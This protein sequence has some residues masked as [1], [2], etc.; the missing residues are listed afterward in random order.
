M[1]ASTRLLVLLLFA[2]FVAASII[3][4]VS[5]TV[6]SSEN[7]GR[8]NVKFVHLVAFR[9][10][11]RNQ[12]QDVDGAWKS[13]SDKY[14]TCLTGK[15]DIL[16]YCRKV[17]PNENITNIVEYSHDVNVEKW[18]REDG[19]SCKFTHT[20]KPYRCIVGEFRSEALQVSHGCRFGH[21]NGRSYCKDYSYWQ[22]VAGD[23]CT[24]KSEPKPM[25]V[26]S[27]AML[28]P[29][30][31]DMFRGVEFVCCP[32]ETSDKQKKPN[33]VVEKTPEKNVDDDEEDDD[34]DDEDDYEEYDDEHDSSDQTIMQDAYFKEID[35]EN[36]HEKFRD[37]ERRLDKK[38]RA[39][40][41]K[42]INEWT[43]LMERY[44][45]MKVDDP[46][47]AEK[48]KTE[49]VARFRK[50]VASLE[51]ENREQRKQIED[52]HEERVQA[53][54]NE[55]KRQAT[56]DYRSALALQVG[57]PN[58]PNVLKTLKAY[59]RAE[60]K[61]RTHMLNRYRHL[62]RTDQDEAET[63]KD[64][65]LYR[66]RYIDL[67]INGTLAMLR[68]FP[69]LEKQVRPIAVEFWR[70]YRHENTPEISSEELLK[71][72]E[73][74]NNEKLINLYKQIY[75][76][77]RGND[78]V[79]KKVVEAS[80]ASP[81][82][83]TT[84]AKKSLAKTLLDTSDSDEDDEELKEAEKSV[85]KKDDSSKTAESKEDEKEDTES[86]EDDD[87]ED[88]EYADEDEDEKGDKKEEDDSEWHVVVEPIRSDT[89]RVHD[90]A[91]APPSYARHQPL[92]QNQV[93]GEE[94]STLMRSYTPYVIVMIITGTIFL[95]ILSV[96]F[97]RRRLQ[98]AGFIEV[99]V[100]TPEER[101]V[102]GMQVNGY[103]NPTYSFFDSKP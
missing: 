75:D 66:L 44:K 43:S 47:G 64:I 42:V 13:D 92:V 72:G 96:V 36:E 59:I 67:R 80:T 34:E 7:A 22:T 91:A 85:D 10:G 49:M 14:A 41:A 93:S 56:H 50:T 103:E 102:N 11:Y 90:L 19:K 77:L 57:K 25:K 37:A 68:D 26:Q 21:V 33:G 24:K 35:L 76:D 86:D 18:C 99:D 45:K 70:D 60:E 101:H 58:K 79:E 89:V 51:E 23:E 98:R 95:G 97:E 20:V 2:P 4:S 9:C 17:Y 84:A 87:D 94:S 55:K 5:A 52:V 31:L 82:T 73:N 38:H 78:E 39:K 40:V 71:L 16:K 48:F 100:C 54:L 32:G 8:D 53:S 28:E 15:L 29:C 81:V 83:T 1:A 74:G 46:K 88:I 63:F 30:G 27:F 6:D 12:Y 61:D 3:D 62:L 69:D 65:L